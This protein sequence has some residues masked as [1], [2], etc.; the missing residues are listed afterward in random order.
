MNNFTDIFTV[1]F[2]FASLF[3]MFS[4]IPISLFESLTGWAI[5]NQI[6]LSLVFL[7]IAIDHILGTFVHWSIKKDFS[8]KKNLYGLLT[9]GFAVC[10]GYVLFEMIH[11]IVDD[12]QFVATYF[13]VILQLTVMLYPVMSALRNLSLITEGKFPPAIWFAKLEGFTKDLSLKHFK[14]ENDLHNSISKYD[15]IDEQLPN[16]QESNDQK[17]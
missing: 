3:T 1:K 4:A 11:Q 8:A 13:K 16:D 14:D 5:N 12:V 17:K 6:F 2:L 15:P 7:A 10:A 9:K